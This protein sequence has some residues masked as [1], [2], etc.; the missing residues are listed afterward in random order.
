MS[1][2]CEIS[3][4]TIEPEEVYSFFQRLKDEVTQHLEEIA[5]E[6]AFYCP[7]QRIVG[8]SELSRE[9]TRELDRNWAY[10][11]FTYRYFYLPKHKLLG[12][13]S[14]PNGVKGIFDNTIAFQNSCDQ[15]YP[16]HA[17]NGVALFEGIAKKWYHCSK[18]MIEKRYAEKH[19]CDFL[20]EYKDSENLAYEYDYSRRSFIYDEIWSICE[21][22]LTNQDEVVHI[23]LYSDFESP[24][25]SAYVHNCNEIAE[26]ELSEYVPK[27]R[28]R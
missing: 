2:Y 11:C 26:K 21:R 28:K 19:G 1:Y 14:I 16:Y 23:C 12:V 22:Y 3:F 6:N 25:M 7:A 17:W 24:I 8:Y 13:F 20:E 4:K 15:D 18:K 9:V 5:K 27:G 10:R